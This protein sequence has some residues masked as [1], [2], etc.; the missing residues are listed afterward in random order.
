MAKV[1]G[2]SSKSISNLSFSLIESA[3]LLLTERSLP[4]YRYNINRERPPV[5]GGENVNAAAS[6]VM[7]VTGLDHH[8]CRLK[9]LRDMAVHEPPLSYA[10]YFNWTFKDSLSSKLRKLLKKPGEK[11]LLSQLI[12]MTVCR[13]S[14]VHPKFYTVTHSW[15]ADFNDK[16]LK[17]KLSPGITLGNK[18]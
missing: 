11:R 6:I 2:S 17:A 13:D 14:I 12:E 16:R 7:L 15:D 8:L 18:A 3:F 10:P 1:R 4:V 5:A 9:Y